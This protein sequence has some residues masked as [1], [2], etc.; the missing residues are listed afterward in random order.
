MR[1]STTS[2]GTERPLLGLLLLAE[3][4]LAVTLIGRSAAAPPSTPVATPASLTTLSAAPATLTLADGRTVHLVGLGGPRSAALLHRIAGQMAGA[5]DAVT[6]FWGSDWQHD[7][8]VTATGSDAQ[9]AGLAGGSTD[10]AAAATADHV[11]P[12]RRTATGQRIVF[13]PGAAAM[14]DGALRIVLRHE[15][16]HYASRADTALDAPRWLTEGVADFVARP[17][18]NPPEPTQAGAL[19]QLPTDADLDTPGATRALAYDR[20]WWFSRFVADRYG[21]AT[22]RALYLRACGVGHAGVAA[23]VHDTL[24]AG[25]PEVLY[26]WQQWLTG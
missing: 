7:V 1:R 6:A 5:V 9:F 16:F 4:I 15:L 10:I 25:L 8:V 13:A 19:A 20:A 23:A 17:D 22:L 3:L 24:G 14:S 12:A 18:A 26:R 2:V 21:T 11:D